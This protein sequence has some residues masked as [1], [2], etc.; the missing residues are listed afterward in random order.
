MLLLA[1]KYRSVR[2]KLSRLEIGCSTFWNLVHPGVSRYSILIHDA[3]NPPEDTQPYQ[4]QV[5]NALV[6]R[7][8]VSNNPRYCFT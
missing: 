8:G 1:I 7:V 6:C 2:V 5:E 3:V 4:P